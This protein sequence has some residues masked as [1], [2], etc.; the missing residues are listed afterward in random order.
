VK[1]VS[2]FSRAVLRMT[3]AE[4]FQCSIF[5]YCATAEVKQFRRLDTE[6][7]LLF[8]FSLISTVRAVNQIVVL[9]GIWQS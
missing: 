2:Y 7:F 4:H 5:T 6:F 9:L 8:Y 1:R 3:S